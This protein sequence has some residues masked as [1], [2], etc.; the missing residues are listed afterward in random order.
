LAGRELA[1]EATLAEAREGCP[2]AGRDGG[3]AGARGDAGVVTVY[4]SSPKSQMQADKL[5]DM[6]V[7]LSFAVV[8]R[9]KWLGDYVPSFSRLLLDSGAYSEFTGA[10]KVSL[11]AYAEWAAQFPF[12][13]GVAAL[14]DIRGD[15]ERGMEN[16]RR[17]PAMFPTFHNS[18]PDEALD[19]ILGYQ[20]RW[21]GLG[22]VPPRDKTQWLDR[23]LARIPPGIHVHGW[24]LRTYGDRPRIDSF[25]STNWFRDVKYLL[26]DPKTA[27]LTPAECLEVIV[28]RYQREARTPRVAS[29]QGEL[30]L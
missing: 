1:G 25:D 30:E 29:P 3:P 22:M 15:W 5:R 26:L 21:L 6:P 12:A 24:A 9:E 8:G 20:P 10:A 4:L 19:V 27:H 2:G 11:D 28:K 17:Y 18:D 13:D 14:D 23:T 7:L 16:W